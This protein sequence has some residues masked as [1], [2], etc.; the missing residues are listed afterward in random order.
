M[1]LWY[2]YYKK[3]IRYLADSRLLTDKP[4]P[5]FQIKYLNLA[6]CS[7][8][9][10]ESLI[11]LCNQG[12]FRSIKH[13]NL[14]GCSQVTDK[15]MKFFSGSRHIQKLQ[16]LYYNDNV[17]A[18]KWNTMGLHEFIPFQLKSLDLSMCSVTDKS[19]EYMCRMISIEDNLERLCLSGC[20]NVSDYGIRIL[21]LNCKMLVDLN[22][23]K[24]AK[25]TARSLKDIKL[26]CTSC[27]IQHTN[28]SFC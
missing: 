2:F 3:G 24:C 11:H 8:I 21:A 27:V 5:K 23:K 28:F 7:Q 12:F 6:K 25:I 26:N 17:D 16:S 14:R 19:L 1:F 13:L 9:T 10:D 4:S 18:K 20:S 22:V 15:F